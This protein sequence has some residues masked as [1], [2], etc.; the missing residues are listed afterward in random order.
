MKDLQLRSLLL[1]LFLV[2]AAVSGLLLQLHLLDVL[3]DQN[4]LS[5][6]L[7]CVQTLEHTV[8]QLCHV[9]LPLLL[10][11]CIHLSLQVLN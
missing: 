8:L 4:L 2:L 1:L 5:Q 10:L 6:V 3:K 9:Q 7:Q 11:V